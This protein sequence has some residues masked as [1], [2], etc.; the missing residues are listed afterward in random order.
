MVQQVADRGFRRLFGES[1]RSFDFSD[2]LRIDILE[3]AGARQ[4][5][6]GEI[7][8]Q[9]QD[10]IAF[11]PKPGFFSILVVLLIAGVV[12]AVAVGVAEQERGAAS[13][14]GS[15]EGLGE[16]LADGQ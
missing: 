9:L 10:R 11:P 15:R 16:R 12:A 5:V 14:A 3:L 1:H 6:S 2:S 13:I 7:A 4:S 8:G